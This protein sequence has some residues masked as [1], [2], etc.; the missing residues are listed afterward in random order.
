MAITL[1]KGQRI[2]LTKG[3]ASLS[4]VM[5]GLGWDPVQAKSG[6]GLLGSLFGGGSSSNANI[7]CDASVLMLEN[8]KFTRKENLVYFGNLKSNCGSVQHSGD[9]LTGA[10]DGD[11]EQVTVDLQKVPA[12]I[13]KL[14]FVVN[15][16]NCVA[17][18][19]DFGMIQNAFIRLVNLSSQ[20]EMV[21]FNLTEKHSGKTSLILGEMYR[22][23]G[24]W[25][26]AAIGDGT[27]DT[28]ISEVVRRYS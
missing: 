7:D 23:N 20:E 13:T 18:K 16:Y 27:T 25:K 17:R 5:V 26:F 14:V 1:Q 8:D 22:H 12:N 19:Q 28:S 9:N 15:I 3:N 10:G 21:K 2:D 24:E 6:G 4:K 11:D